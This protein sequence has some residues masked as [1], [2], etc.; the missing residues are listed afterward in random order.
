M[1]ACRLAGLRQH[2]PAGTRG[3]ATFLP[4]H[5]QLARAA[6]RVRAL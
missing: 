1:F 3:P 6:N 4:R 5:H 2:Q